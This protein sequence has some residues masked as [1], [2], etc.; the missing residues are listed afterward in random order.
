MK[1]FQ[2]LSLALLLGAC[3]VSAFA[4]S[5]EVS[6]LNQPIYTLNC[7]SSETAKDAYLCVKSG[8]TLCYEKASRFP[9]GRSTYCYSHTKTNTTPTCTNTVERCYDYRDSD[10]SCH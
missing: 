6:I 3:S 4:E 9:N 5:F 2:K 10:A 7:T 1:M 8:C